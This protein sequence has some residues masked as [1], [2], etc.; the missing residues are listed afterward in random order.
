MRQQRLP[1]LLGRP[2][3]PDVRLPRLPVRVDL[4]AVLTSGG[5]LDLR[6]RGGRGTGGRGGLYVEPT[7]DPTAVSGP[8]AGQHVGVG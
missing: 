8:L 3:P 6:P 1:R 7:P 5:Q 4:S 2:S